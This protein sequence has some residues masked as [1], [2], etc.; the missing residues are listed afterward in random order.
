MRNRSNGVVAAFSVGVAFCVCVAGCTAANPLFQSG[1]DLSLSENGDGGS[2]ATDAGATDLPADLT[3]NDLVAVSC[4][5]SQTPCVLGSGED[6]VCVGGKCSYCV[7]SPAADAL[8]SAAYDEQRVCAAG[9]CVEGDCSDSADCASR[10]CL[11]HHCDNCA[12]DQECNDDPV[13]GPDY[14]CRGGACLPRACTVATSQPTLGCDPDLPTSV[15]C[16]T[17]ST[18]GSLGTCQMGDCCND[19]DCGSDG[20]CLKPSGSPLLGGAGV[21][22]TCAV[23]PVNVRYVRAETGS[24]T[25][26]GSEACPFATVTR[27]LA[28][29]PNPAPSGTTI[30][31]RGKQFSNELGD[32]TYPLT[33]PSNVRLTNDDY[34]AAPPLYVVPGAQS[35]FRLTGKN[36][37]IGGSSSLAQIVVD[38]AEGSSGAHVGVTIESDAEATLENFVA[39]GF[40]Q[41]GSL[42]IRVRAGG[43]LTLGEG[44]EIR[45]NVLGVS[46]EGTS[47]AAGQ[48]LATQTAP[49][50]LTSI[51][52]EDNVV[53]LAASGSGFFR[54]KGSS[55]LQSI[56][57]RQ[58]QTGVD[59]AQQSPPVESLNVIDG[60]VIT[61]AAGGTGLSIA[62]GSRLSLRRSGFFDGAISVA[63]TG[64]ITDPTGIDLGHDGELGDNTLR[65][66]STAAGLC[67]K[68]ASALS[69]PLSARGNRFGNLNCAATTGT[70][71]HATGNGCTAQADIGVEASAAG[72]VILSNYFDVASCSTGP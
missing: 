19:S 39:K 41:T 70:L 47:A 66:N 40:E 26:N 3:T 42:G 45:D 34:F 22:K 16:S 10:V 30:Y 18:T 64:T 67:V 8:C 54:L 59:I 5:G 51:L 1:T 4:Q 69:K 28:T 37:R 57:F 48:L 25:G 12:G 71:T 49:S 60:V 20:L 43:R 65:W 15:C 17:T 24:D 35:A 31:V 44:T 6:G 9:A 33:I 61:A 68:T 55:L 27:A 29:L 7:D 72:N 2:L 32:E 23:P 56:S 13:Y 46:V 14:E 11:N 63:I 52:F 58:N 62:T 36:I 53:A 21:C 50:M 38:G